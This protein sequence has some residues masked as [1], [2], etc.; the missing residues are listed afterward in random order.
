LRERGH[1]LAVFADDGEKFGGWP[2]TKEWVYGKGW[3]DKFFHTINGLRDSGQVR[4]VTGATALRE[5]PGGGIAYLPTASY[6]E[7][8]AWALPPHA[9]T[10][11]AR[12]EQELGEER[13]KASESLVRGGHW[14]N[15]LVKYSESNRMHKMMTA[16]SRLSR[17]QGDP[18]AAR[19]AI[20]R[21]QC[22]DAYWHGVFG[23]LYLPVLRG[24]V[25]RQLA[26]AERELRAGEGLAIESVDLDGDGEL[27][28]W[29][30]S[31]EF[32]ALVSPR[33]GGALEMLLWFAAELN[34]VD[35]L[36]RRRE[37]YHEDP[38]GGGALPPADTDPRAMFVDR[39][40][41]GHV[42][43]GRYVAGGYDTLMS[44][45]TLGFI[46]TIRAGARSVEIALK[47][48]D[49]SK[50]FTF[51]FDGTLTAQYR[52]DPS[53]WPEGSFFAPEL[54][55]SREVTL[56]VH[57]E[58]EVWSYPIKTVGKSERG[59]EETTQGLAL[60]PRWPIAAG[61]ATLEIPPP[62]PGSAV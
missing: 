23:G 41:P 53:R 47:G 51:A 49:L 42:D 21:A 28:F 61:R 19:R 29:V 58:V 62:Q 52:W 12:L 30:H 34:L 25:W 9:Q 31:S 11:L 16:L 57:P 13:F 43:H 59:L 60:T 20:G 22:N 38:P 40:L 27:E 44:W 3:L 7:M 33:R 32:S 54:S 46:P 37:A 56:A 1:R 45:A 26:I 4:L 55:L 5:T 35:V 18:P 15:F 17:A 2:G 39:V 24:A 10:R 36:T 14:R 48:H 8:E 6:R 50:S